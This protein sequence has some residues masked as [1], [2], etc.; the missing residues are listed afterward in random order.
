MKFLIKRFIAGFLDILLL[1]CIG[2]VAAELLPHSSSMNTSLIICYAM[3]LKLHHTTPG[4]MILGLKVTSSGKKELGFM[5]SFWRMLIFS[6]AI[7]APILLVMFGKYSYAKALLISLIALSINVLP[8]FLTYDRVMIHDVLSRSFVEEDDRNKFSKSE[9]NKLWAIF[10][11]MLI[12]GVYLLN[13]EGDKVKECKKIFNDKKYEEVIDSCA[14]EATRT[15]NDSLNLLVGS[16][17]LKLKNYKEAVNYFRAAD[18]MGNKSAS[19]LIAY[20][21]MQNKEYKRALY[22]SKKKPKDPVMLFFTSGIYLEKF[23][24]TRNPDDLVKAIAYSRVIRSYISNTKG[25]NTTF[26]GRI[27]SS[28][29]SSDIINKYT[30]KVEKLS[31]SFLSK[32]RTLEVEEMVDKIKEKGGKL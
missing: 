15:R 27:L 18:I 5:R 3:V 26:E 1:I 23:T 14:D 11:I 19:Y 31:K 12:A 9:K 28:F 32:E 8:S 16:A 30:G 13:K 21:Y 6:T 22:W 25:D 2:M 20:S 4:G 17:N 29:T 7:S 24:K 10:I